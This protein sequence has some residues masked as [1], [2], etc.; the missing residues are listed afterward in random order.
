MQQ[1]KFMPLRYVVD[2]SL[3]RGL[4]V[5]FGGKK[6]T[7]TYSFCRFGNAGSLSMSLPVCAGQ[8]SRMRISCCQFDNLD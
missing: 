8:L 4:D 3:I 7:G 2:S 6:A 5:K 1:G